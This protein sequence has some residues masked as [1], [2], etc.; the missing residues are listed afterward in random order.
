[1][2]KDILGVSWQIVPDV[3]IEMLN[4]KDL[5][6]AKRVMQAMLQMGK[7]DISR[8]QAAYNGV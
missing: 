8:L 4:A 1:M 2:L 5:A 7:I 6:K 3:L